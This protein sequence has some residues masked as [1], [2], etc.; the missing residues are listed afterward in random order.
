MSLESVITED[1]SL[2]CRDRDT[3][4]LYHNRAGAYLEALKNYVEPS[5][6]CEQLQLSNSRTN[7][8][9]LDQCFGLGYNS[10]VLID[11]LSRN[12]NDSEQSNGRKETQSRR[13]T[14]DAVEIDAE[15]L[16]MVPLVLQQPCFTNLT[17]NFHVPQDALAGFGEHILRGRKCSDDLIEIRILNVDLRENLRSLEEEKVTNRYD[18]IFHDPFSPSKVPEFWTVDMFRVYRQILN[19]SFGRVLTY[20]SASAVRGGLVEAGFDVWR[21]EAVGGKSGGTMATISD[22]DSQPACGF[23]LNVEETARLSTASGVPYRDPSLSDS[24]DE[25]LARRRAEQASFQ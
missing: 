12:R 6:V 16:S 2:T 14:I 25:I 24:R 11:Q 3:G 10:L 21:T 5:Q 8:V 1:G 9:V 15:I 20:S 7:I 13:I 23:A 17:E 4:E 19:T 18:L 22:V